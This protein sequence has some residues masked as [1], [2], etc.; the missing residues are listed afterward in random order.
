MEAQVKDVRPWR[1]A[2][3]TRKQQ[4]ATAPVSIVG[5]GAVVTLHYFAD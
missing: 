3:T 1:H 4:I 2:A 5:I